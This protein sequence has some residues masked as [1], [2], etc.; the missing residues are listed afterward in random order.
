MQ[1]FVFAAAYFER[2]SPRSFG[3]E[4]V[5]KQLYHRF[6]QCRYDDLKHIQDVLLPE[7]QETYALDPTLVGR[8]IED[9]LGLILEI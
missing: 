8:F 1:H 9:T 5:F 6:K 4:T 7:I 2:Y 3:L